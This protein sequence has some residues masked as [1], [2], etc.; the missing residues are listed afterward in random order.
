MSGAGRVYLRGKWWWISY[1]RHAREYRQSAHTQSEQVAHRLLVRK[2][3]EFR[4]A[5][6]ERLTIDDL[7]SA[8]RDDYDLRG[9]RAMQVILRTDSPRIRAAFR[10]IRLV[11]LKA[12]KIR[13][14]MRQLRAEGL[15]DATINGYLTLVR[16]GFRLL[17]QADAISREPYIKLLPLNNARQGFIEPA[18]FEQIVERLPAAF[19]DPMRF[20][21]LSGWRV[22]EMMQLLWREIDTSAATWAIRLPP[23]KTKTRKA[24][25]LPLG[26][27]LRELIERQPRTVA[28]PHV[29][30][31]RGRKIGRKKLWMAWTAAAADAGFHGV[32]VHDLR[33]S[34]VRNMVRAGI[35]ERVAM[36]FTGHT[37][38]A[39][40]DRYHIVN[41]TDMLEAQERLD[42]WAAAAPE[43]KVRVIKERS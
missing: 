15:A 35:P 1:F 23:E 2:M 42:A 14:W 12:D 33:R 31:Y 40:F 41:S 20:L 24:R 16:R 22:G 11:D 6:E 10:D 19:R 17:L 18:D 38:R 8:L 37:S 34:A 3:R 30:Q 9:R 13:S 26:A 25:T 21:Y 4:P 28:C 43:S 5:A 36:E 7:L 27:A 39:I 29:F 32:I